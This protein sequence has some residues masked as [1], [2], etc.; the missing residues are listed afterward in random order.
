MM[1]RLRIRDP[2]VDRQS[3]AFPSARECRRADAIHFGSVAQRWKPVMLRRVR[4]VLMTGAL[5]AVAWSPFGALMGARQWFGWGDHFG[6]S[7]PPSD[8]VYASP[9]LLVALAD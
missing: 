5:W 7:S 8:L 1:V 6:A 3:G 4:A 9:S 2:W